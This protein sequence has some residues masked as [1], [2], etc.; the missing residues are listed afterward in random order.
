VVYRN[1]GTGESALIGQLL[2][3]LNAIPGAH[4]S[5][6]ADDQH[7]PSRL[8]DAL[9]ALSLAGHEL[10]I[11]VEARNEVYPRD[12]SRIMWAYQSFA[13]AD[14]PARTFML[15]ARA[16]SPGARQTL[17][18]QGIG[19]FDSSGSL[20]LSAGPFHIQIDRPPTK[21]VQRSIRSVFAGRKAHV[22]QQLLLHPDE[23]LNVTQLALHADVSTATVSQLLRELERLD[24]VTTR[25]RG[26]TKERKVSS[27]GALLDAYAA[28][29]AGT[30]VTR[31]Q[32][33]FVPGNFRDELVTAIGAKFDA[34]N[35]AYAVSFEAAGQ[36][37]APYLTR[38]PQVRGR[39]VQGR[40]LEEALQ[41]MGAKVVN[42]GANLWLAPIT[43]RREL[44]ATERVHDVWL[45]NPVQ[46]YLDLMFAEGRSKELAGQL[47]Q[48]KL[49]Y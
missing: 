16:I 43:N 40:A 42:E 1:E 4:A 33:Y 13:N 10:Q 12:A 26:P 23:W 36:L 2:D 45:A 22:L 32:K 38:V 17:Q 14:K 46:V 49:K 11:A 41:S 44:T 20:Y 47:R 48:E 31:F 29:Y 39:A 15:A 19:Y 9:V 35:V 30:R 37:Y 27:P 8:M 7:P 5:V 28:N 24:Y 18:N 34:A 21:A 6:L 25:G 3:A